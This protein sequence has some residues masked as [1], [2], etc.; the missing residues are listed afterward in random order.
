MAASGT[1]GARVSHRLGE[2]VKILDL[3]RSLWRERDEGRDCYV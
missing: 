1:M 2:G 3:L